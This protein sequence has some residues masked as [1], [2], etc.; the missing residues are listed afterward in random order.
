[1]IALAIVF[2]LIFQSFERN[3]A[4]G[5]WSYSQ[6]LDNAKKG[7]VRSVVISGNQALATEKTGKRWRVSL[8]EDTNPT[9]QQLIADRVDV[10]YSGTGTTSTWLGVL[11][12]NVILLTLIGGF[13]Y[14]IFRRTRHQPPRS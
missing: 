13:M 7:D 1:M 12:P 10:R 6:L 8:P 14:F 5:N 3:D 11:V 4:N 9:A 2:Y